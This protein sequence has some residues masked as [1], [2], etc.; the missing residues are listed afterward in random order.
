VDFLEENS[1]E[2]IHVTNGQDALDKTYAQKFDI[3]LLD[4]NVPIIDGITLLKELRNASDDTPTIFLTSH[5]EK[6]VLKNSYLSGGDDFLTKPFDL[7]ELMFR[8]EALL[9][10]SKPNKVECV[11][12]LCHDEAHH[13]IMYKGKEVDLAKKEYQLLVL[14]MKHLNKTVPKE[15]ITNELWSTSTS[16]SDGALR[17]YINRLKQLLPELKIENIRGIGY[18]LVS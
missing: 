7:D 12:S 17:V 3:Y 13:C 11:E 1:L 6:E 18:K 8:I 16:A 14:L 9:R 10:R 4:I 5:T 2:V 15:M